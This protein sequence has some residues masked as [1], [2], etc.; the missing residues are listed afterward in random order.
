MD[1]T[2]REANNKIT[3]APQPKPCS[4][5]TN[6]R[7][8]K[9]VQVQKQSKRVNTKTNCDVDKTNIIANK[10]KSQTHHNQSCA[11]TERINECKNK[12]KNKKTTASLV[13]M[14]ERIKRQKQNEI[15]QCKFKPATTNNTGHQTKQTN[16]LHLN[17]TD[18][19][20]PLSTL[21]PTNSHQEFKMLLT[22]GVLK[23]NS[24]HLIGCAEAV[25][26]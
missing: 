19:Y 10:I 15:C 1:K 24:L 13:R 14:K 4:H 23:R 3:D 12:Y 7:M 9:Q 25:W 26:L 20:T 22:P 18:T 5:G 2:N 8:Q 16:P 11:V 21:R 6:E 17:N